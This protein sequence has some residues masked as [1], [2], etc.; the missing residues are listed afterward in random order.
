VQFL[1]IGNAGHRCHDNRDQG[2]EEISKV[3]TEVQKVLWLA[4]LTQRIT[5][6]AKLSLVATVGSNVHCRNIEIADYLARLGYRRILG[7]AIC[8]IPAAVHP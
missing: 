8:V 2:A 6:T 4:V 1:P 5:C 7:N 3:E